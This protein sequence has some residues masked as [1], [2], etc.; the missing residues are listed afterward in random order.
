MIMNRITI[1]NCCKVVRK[2]YLLLPI[3]GG[4]WMG[5]SSCS[6]ETENVFG[7]QAA[8]RLQKAVES[9]STTLE[10]ATQGW[11]MDFYPG[12]LT[13]GGIAYTAVFKDGRVTLSCERPIDYSELVSKSEYIYA[14]GQEVNS[15]YTVKSENSIVLSFDTFNALIHYWAQPYG[16][17]ADGYASDYEF[18]FLSCTDSEVLLRGKKHDKLLRLTPLTQSPATYIAQVMATRANLG[19]IPRK[20]AVVNGQTLNIEC[21]NNHLKYQ[22]G[23]EKRDVPFTYTDSGLRFYEPVSLGGFS[24]D[25]MTYDAAS[26][27]LR[28]PDGQIVMLAPTS[29]ERFVATTKQWY[30]GY[31]KKAGTSDMCDELKA[32]VDAIVKNFKSAGW[33]FEVLNDIYL[34]INLQS[35]AL[36][37][38]RMVLGWHS[39]TG[40]GSGDSNYFCYGVDMDTSDENLQ[41]VVIKPTEAGVGF[42]TKTYCKPLVDFIA[43]GSPY[44][45]EFNDNDHPTQA[46]LTSQAD[47]GKWFVLTIRN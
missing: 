34:G 28:S 15:S 30:F 11:A 21:T 27:E 25:A 4:G 26:R 6:P 13:D 20:R 42:D 1:N 16:L 33:G 38:H 44:T 41:L 43:A 47:A 29:T 3:L 40:Y 32:I 24:C 35:A 19:D 31:D 14:A 39:R 37:E 9:Y 7:E 18:T 2:I 23:E 22:D 8:L 36:D 45:L 46:R 5:V 17:K 10:S 12:D